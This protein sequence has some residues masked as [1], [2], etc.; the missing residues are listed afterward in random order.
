MKYS[1]E[2]RSGRPDECV[3]DLANGLKTKDAD[4]RFLYLTARAPEMKNTNMRI[5]QILEIARFAG[6]FIG[7][8]LAFRQPSDP[9]RA[10]HWLSVCVVASIAGMTG[11]ESLFFGKQG[12]SASG[13]SDPGPYQRQSAFN[14]LSVAIVS[15]AVFA[16]NWGPQAEAA[17]CSVLLVFLTLSS[18]NHV[19]SAWQDGN[20]SWRGLTRPLGVLALLIAVLPF[21]FRALAT[22]S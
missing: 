4:A 10:F 16:M 3:P 13:Y 7:F 5:S 19:H 20:R 14:N 18:I 8:C 12:A 1:H 21:M 9:Q 11:I 6:V 17:I 15:L 22:S 2:T